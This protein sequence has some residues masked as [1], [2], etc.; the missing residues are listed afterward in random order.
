MDLY[1]QLFISKWTLIAVVFTILAYIGLKIGK[2]NKDEIIKTTT[3]IAF[4]SYLVVTIL[5]GIITYE[6]HF[7]ERDM[8]K[9]LDRIHEEEGQDLVLFVKYYEKP[10]NDEMN[11]R[12]YAGNYSKEESFKG[13]ILVDMQREDR[14]TM[15]KENYKNIQLKT[16]E[17]VELASFYT[18]KKPGMFNYQ[19]KR[20][21]N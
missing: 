17:K 6:A 7:H 1:P 13:D 9:E 21:S 16:D 2:Y 5:V 8:V 18:K 12:V 10:D 20:I 3:K 11:V 14:K 19:F 15:K 4:I